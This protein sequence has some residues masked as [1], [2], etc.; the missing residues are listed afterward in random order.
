M[1]DAARL[2]RVRPW[3]GAVAVLWLLVL[4]VAG[5]LSGKLADVVE[6]SQASFLPDSAESTRVL[7][8][9]KAFAGADVFPTLL[10]YERES[11]IT[12]A[13]RAVAAQDAAQVAQVEGVVGVLPAELS[14]DG[15]ALQVVAAV[16]GS[17]VEALPD[18]V[19][20]VRAIVDPAD[21]LGAWVTGIGGISAD[22]F[23]VFTS[24]DGPLLLATAGV[25]VL[26]LLL[27]YRSPVLWLLPLLCCGAAFSTAAAIVYLLAK[28]D[29]MTVDA[30][31]Q[32]ILT[33]LVFGA[34][35]D[36]ALLLVARYR[37]ELH[38]FERPWDAMRVALRGAVPAIVA[39]A[40]TVSLGLLCLLASDLGSNRGLGPVTAIGVAC[41][42]LAMTTL[43][44]ALLVLIGRA[45]FWPR[46]PKA[47]HL[48]L[49]E[50]GIW[51]RVSDHVGAHPRRVS[52]VSGAVLLL[53]ALGSTQ[54]QASG[55]GQ[56]DF[57]TE[58]NE[59]VVGQEV[60][61]A[62]F[63]A[64]SG[65]PVVVV[66]PVE[67]ADEVKRVVEADRNVVRTAFQP[68]DPRDPSSP[69]AEKDGLVL[70][71]ATLGVSGDGADAQQV[72]D[73]LREEVDAVS[74]EVL[75]G[76]S[77]AINLDVQ[78]ASQRDNRVII[79]LVLLVILVVLG[80]LLR[81][82]VAPLMLVG[83]VV[84]SYAATLGVCA[85]FFN[86]VF[87]FA[88]ADSS[89][90]LFSFV[91]LVALGI[92]YNIFL[93]SRVREETAETG[94]TREGTLKG[95][96]VTGGVITSAGVVLAGTFAVLGV[97][98]L[99]PLAQIGFAVAFGVLLDT[100]IVRSLLVPALTLQLDQRTW[101]PSAL[102]R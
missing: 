4:A 9:E 89:F 57:F 76:G 36:Y 44:P 20:E 93:M 95:L 2:R 34:G 37:E 74:E 50:H 39:S 14:E 59:S 67:S 33:V 52:L 68:V 63:D 102:S 66:A 101:W 40:A 60:V 83:T 64:G 13:D 88:G 18:V 92:D 41:A 29:V 15:K 6:N 26:I 56:T 21:G 58:R 32:G 96:A 7:E 62:H 12:A 90:P 38:E 98:P 49:T 31:S 55:L 71:N 100:V 78:R 45:V 27:V 46:V 47:D 1:I 10:V 54:L 81:A 25:V 99:V 23:E 28:A 75:V 61:E 43:L 94:S 5:P 77:T 24:I 69:R 8:V 79:P 35:T 22:Q 53:L 3:A 70:L 48:G 73:D 19:A 86:E 87:D 65:R 42:V 97:L 91:F 80:L 17:D 72:V 30:Q 84:L 11:G 82:V 51:G 16:D 85:F